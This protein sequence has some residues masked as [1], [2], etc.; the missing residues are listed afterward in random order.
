MERRSSPRV[1]VG[2]KLLVYHLGAP[3]AIGQLRD[4]SRRGLFV[5]SDL[6]D[7]YPQQWLEVELLPRASTHMDRCRFQTWVARCTPEGFGLEVD[8]FTPSGVNA[9]G[10]L[11]AS[12]LV[13]SRVR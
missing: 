1:A 13:G 7:I 10:A 4:V 5:A 6:A 3:V 11:L 8:M 2:M 12:T 9:L